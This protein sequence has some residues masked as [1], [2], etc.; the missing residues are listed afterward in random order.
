MLPQY[1]ITTL[2]TL[3]STPRSDRRK[4]LVRRRKKK[5]AD[6]TTMSAGD[7]SSCSGE[8]DE[9]VDK[10]P[11]KNQIAINPN[12]PRLSSSG[13]TR[14]L[15]KDS[16]LHSV[17][18]LSSVSLNSSP[19]RMSTRRASDPKDHEIKI[20][21]LTKKRSSISFDSNSSSHSRSSSPRIDA[22]SSSRRGSILDSPRR[23]L[24]KIFGSSARPHLAAEKISIRKL[25]GHGASARVFEAEVAGLILAAKIYHPI[26][27]SILP[28]SQSEKAPSKCVNSDGQCTQ[29]RYSQNNV[30]DISAPQLSLQ[31]KQDA[32]K[33]LPEHQHVLG[34]F[35]YRFIKST[36]LVVLTELM[37]CTL[38]DLI[39]ERREQ[40][41][42]DS[43]SATINPDHHQR[44]PS[45]KILVTSPFRKIEVIEL[46]RQIVKGVHFLHNPPQPC[47]VPSGGRLTSIWHR[48]LKSENIMCKKM[49]V[50]L[51]HLLVDDPHCS[52][53]SEMVSEKN[54]LHKQYTL[55]IGDFDEARI[56]YDLSDSSSPVKW[57]D[58]PDDGVEIALGRRRSIF[59]SARERLSLNIGT[60]QFMAPEMMFKGSAKYDEKVDIWSLGMILYELLTLDLPYSLDNFNAI[61]LY[62][63]IQSG[64][65]PV[66]PEGYLTDPSSEWLTLL[67]I[68]RD[69]TE[70]DPEKRPSAS[71]LL[72]RLSK[73]Q[74][75]N[76]I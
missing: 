33:A 41:M 67:Q 8:D 7:H 53:S 46:F 16:S 66:I 12:H 44:Q 58:E 30:G 76:N 63:M 36:R 50:D 9:Q 74:T 5:S 60:L 47:P 56:V 52:I 19:L 31:Q 20:A 43:S 68:F 14:S 26:I 2:T 22:A 48:D 71:D 21:L 37:D 6:A 51:D 70:R 61:E 29:L 42:S 34:I 73:Y 27:T 24:T 28:R 45:G 39:D 15:P 13:K 62:D 3:M 23:F 1:N 57:S 35:D 17:A 4:K 55:K 59:S 69:C 65:R 64:Q 40:Y 49:H 11:I 75:A 32:I 25:I 10:K 38:R 18:P 72:R 54:R